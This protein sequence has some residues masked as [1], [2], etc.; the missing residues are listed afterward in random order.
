MVPKQ[1]T[2]AQRLGYR[3]VSTAIQNTE[4]QLAEVEL[5][6][7][8]VDKASGGS[9]DRPR[10]AA[11]LDHVRAGDEVHVHSIDRLARNLADLLQLVET[12]TGKGASLHFHKEGLHFTGEASPMQA[13]QLSIMGAVAA[14][15]RSIINERAAEGRAAAKARGVR[16][17]RR[18]SLDA[19]AVRAIRAERAAGKTV[20]AIAIDHDV[21]RQAVYRALD[22]DAD[23]A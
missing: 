18:P 14:F 23:A 16:F 3:R 20:S 2:G 4:R 12:I 6:R 21:S 13:L 10:L 15:E 1:R 7:T 19:K 9:A 22:R 17:G 11:L 8:F 5:D